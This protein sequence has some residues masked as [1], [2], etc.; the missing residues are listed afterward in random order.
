MREGAVDANPARTV[1]TP[2][3][4]KYLP[5]VMQPAEVSAIKNV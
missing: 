2:K 5:A 4:E 1:A 3:R